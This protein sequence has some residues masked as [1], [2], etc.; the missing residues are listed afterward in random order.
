M[1]LFKHLQPEAIEERNRSGTTA[2]VF[3]YFWAAGLISLLLA[4]FSAY[5]MMHHP[6]GIA[7]ARTAIWLTF[8]ALSIAGAWQ[9]GRFNRNGVLFIGVAL[10]LSI[11]GWIFDPPTRN[12]IVFAVMTA[13]ALLIAW[14]DLSPG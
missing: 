14:K 4:G 10:G 8:A 1:A 9:M 2:L 3:L 7:A 6:S 12:E 11:V 13:G 5:E